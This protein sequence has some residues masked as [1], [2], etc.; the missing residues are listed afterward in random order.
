MSASPKV[1]LDFA[2]NVQSTPTSPVIIFG[3]LL[4]GKALLSGMRLQYYDH[5]D[6]CDLGG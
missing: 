3:K 4:I 1:V 5:V 6:V 2:Q